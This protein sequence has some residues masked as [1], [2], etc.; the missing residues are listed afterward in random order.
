MYFLA[1]LLSSFC[2]SA[3]PPCSRLSILYS[4]APQWKPSTLRLP[5]RKRELRL[6]V[7]SSNSA[8]LFP[9]RPNRKSDRRLPN[10]SSEP[11]LPNLNKEPLFPNLKRDRL[12][13]KRRS[14]PLLSSSGKSTGTILLGS[15]ASSSS[16]IGLRER[17]A[18]VC[19]I[20]GE[21]AAEGPASRDFAA[22]KA[23]ST[24]RRRGRGRHES[25]ILTSVFDVSVR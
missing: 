8:S 23:H 24:D 4:S 19:W 1:C 18:A 2:R 20:D 25:S 3:H 6:S 22:A 7:K 21:A 10:L 12:L 16:K 14:E 9:D 15:K 13:P 17:L 11:R 5:K